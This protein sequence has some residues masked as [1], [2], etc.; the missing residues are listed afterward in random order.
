MSKLD[1]KFPFGDH[2]LTF[3]VNTLCDLEEAFGV[4]D[5]NAVLDVI[6]TLQ[7]K[8][9]LRTLRTIFRVAL[10]QEHPD[11]T[12]NMAGDIISQSSV[13]DAASAIVAGLEQAFPVAD[14][15]A[16]G[17]APAGTGTKS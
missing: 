13:S 3:N 7:E 5:V 15:S 11:I 10:S 12:D 6:N 17:N 4:A 16:E 9:S 1:G 8:P 14:E 2:T